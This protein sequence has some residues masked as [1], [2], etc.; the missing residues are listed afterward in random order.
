[1]RLRALVGTSV[2]GCLAWL[3][4]MSGLAAWGVEPGSSAAE[5][6]A[7]DVF[8]AIE[9]GQV[10]A[11]FI[12]RSAER[13]RLVIVNRAGTPLRVQLPDAFG[14]RPVLAQLFP[15][16][17][18]QGIFG[19]DTGRGQAAQV[20]AQGPAGNR[21]AN[22]APPPFIFG[23]MMALPAEATIAVDVAGFCLEEGKPEPQARMPYE[24][25][26]LEEVAPSPVLRSLIVAAV[27]GKP[28]DADAAQAAV[29]HLANGRSWDELARLPS[30]ERHPVRGVLPQF[31]SKELKRAREL[32]AAAE[33]RVAKQ[34][35]PSLAQGE[36]P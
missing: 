36:R 17:G 24:L 4:G 22:G 16:G 27:R 30:A 8:A 2:L 31:S 14:G 20:V 15:Q 19:N 18:G 11:R 9:A 23:N 28:A 12:P 33:A 13:G 35:A 1:M 26:P 5:I 32:I 34:A 7:I 3:A 21:G 29:W 25:V 10:E 6:A